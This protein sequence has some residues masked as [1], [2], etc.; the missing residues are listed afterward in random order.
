M[1]E[2]IQRISRLVAEG[3]LSPE[4]G[5][6]LI[7]A[8]VA[9][10]RTE[11]APPSPPKDPLKGV[12]ENLEQKVKGVDWKEIGEQVETGAKKGF[13][14]IRGS[15]EELTKGKVSF[16]LFG[17]EERREVK[18]PLDVP[19]HKRLRIENPCGDVKIVGH[20]ESGTVLAEAR[21]RGG[22]AEEAKARA[23]EYTVIVEESDT[24]V[25]IRQPDVPGL[26]VDLVVRLPEA[27]AVEIRTEMGDVTVL[28]HPAAV[29]ATTRA[30]KRQGDRRTWPRRGFRRQRGRRPR[31]RRVS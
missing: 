8:F 24:L 31:G 18:L 21:L 11:A 5:A 25:V 29:R 30:G 26:A 4:D 15:F 22:T 14:A 7:E 2:E 20:A 23:Q 3:K 9:A 1:K 19:A 27:A 6:E 16:G 10:D 28:G 13:E 12:F 17:N